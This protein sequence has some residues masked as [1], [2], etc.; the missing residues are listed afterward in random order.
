MFKVSLLSL[1]IHRD[2]W[3]R[4]IFIPGSLHI[5]QRKIAPRME[6][7]LEMILRQVTFKIIIGLH[8]SLVKK[9]RSN[10]FASTSET[11]IWRSS[12]SILK[13]RDSKLKILLYDFGKRS[14]G[15]GH[16][17]L[18]AISNRSLIDDQG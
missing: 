18:F 16:K 9:V 6:P 11:V 14:L 15:Q 2:P 4:P 10:M 13:K 5:Q 12:K 3:I 1:H 8:V 7:F 17:T